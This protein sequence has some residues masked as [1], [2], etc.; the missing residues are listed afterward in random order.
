MNG[1]KLQYIS[2]KLSD[3][4]IKSWEMESEENILIVAGTN[5]GKS[6]FIKNR[7]YAYC[8]KHNLKIL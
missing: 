3:E 7:L 1:T 2:D 6:Y 8:K 4:I 5:A